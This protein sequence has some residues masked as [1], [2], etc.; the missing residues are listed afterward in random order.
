MK[1]SR[2]F[3]VFMSVFVVFQVRKNW[4]ILLLK[5]DTNLLWTD[6]KHWSPIFL[7]SVSFS[8]LSLSPSLSG[9]SLSN[10]SALLWTVRS[11]AELV[12]QPH[13]VYTRAHC[14]EDKTLIDWLTLYQGSL[15][16]TDKTLIDYTRA[17]CC[18]QTKH[19]STV[20]EGSLLW[21]DKTLT[22]YEGSLLWTDRT[23][24]DSLYTRAHCCEQTK[25]W[26]T[27]HAC[28]STGGGV[29]EVSE[30]WLRVS[31]RQPSQIWTGQCPPPHQLLMESLPHTSLHFV[32]LVP[33]IYVCVCQSRERGWRRDLN[34]CMV[35]CVYINK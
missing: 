5:S 14:C 7:R 25:H 30:V 31:S 20:Y 3:C 4:Q 6:I 26:L 17:H 27:G 13:R 33:Y 18:E 1:I 12:S 9:V 32:Y 29:Q 19:W 22:V 2:L 8:S 10:V 35:V 23:L 34:T 24:I 28:C 21:T 15:L 16:W 11:V